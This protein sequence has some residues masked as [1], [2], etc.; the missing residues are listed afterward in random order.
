MMEELDELL[1]FGAW[2]VRMLLGSITFVV[3]LLA[4]VL[5][6]CSVSDVVVPLMKDLL[7]RHSLL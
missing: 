3:W 2:C 1:G 6:W 4:L 5:I 7:I